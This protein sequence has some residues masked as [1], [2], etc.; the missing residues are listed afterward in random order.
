MAHGTFLF[1]SVMCQKQEQ[2]IKYLQPGSMEKKEKKDKK[3]KNG[4]RIPGWPLFLFLFYLY[5][6]FMGSIAY[7]SNILFV[8]NSEN[9]YFYLKERPQLK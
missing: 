2:N 1:D 3:K 7:A 6:Y 4:V 5:I 9:A 8:I